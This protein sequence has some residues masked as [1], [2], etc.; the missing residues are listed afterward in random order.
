MKLI[1]VKLRVNSTFLKKKLLHITFVDSVSAGVC[2]TAPKWRS[3]D[4]LVFFYY[5]GPRDETHVF[6]SLGGESLYLLSH[7]AGPP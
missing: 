1:K 3:E 2:I 7:L 4:N 6:V 5:V